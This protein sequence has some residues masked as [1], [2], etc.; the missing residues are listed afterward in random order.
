MIKNVRNKKSVPVCYYEKIC[1]K[2]FKWPFLQI[3]VDFEHF[4]TTR[5]RIPVFQIWIQVHYPAIWPEGGGGS[6][7]CVPNLVMPATYSAWLEAFWNTSLSMFFPLLYNQ[8]CKNT[9]FNF[10]LF[11][12]YTWGCRSAI[13][14]CGSR[15]GSRSG[16]GKS[17]S[18]DKNINWCK[19]WTF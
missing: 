2:M 1:L 8:P 10:C 4:D 17:F 11:K 6:V 5:I 19:K 13:Y 14:S 16:L 9:F 18:H 12:T 7:D 3:K 15:S